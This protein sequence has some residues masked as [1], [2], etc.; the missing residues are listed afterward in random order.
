[1]QVSKAANTQKPAR[2]LPK[3]AVWTV[4]GLVEVVFELGTSLEQQNFKNQNFKM[5]YSKVKNGKY[6]GS[7]GTSLNDRG[8]RR[9]NKTGN[10]HAWRYFETSIVSF[11]ELREPI[12]MIL[13]AKWPQSRVLS[14][15]LKTILILENHRLPFRENHEKIRVYCKKQ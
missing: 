15:K 11:S 10:I 4:C 7:T 1:M 8:L 13:G 9:R 6:F 14:E 12:L 5:L 2:N 3:R